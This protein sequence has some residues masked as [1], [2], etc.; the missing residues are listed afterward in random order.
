MLIPHQ[1][2]SSDALQGL[3]EDFIHRE[4]TD[5]G[6]VEASLED[7]VS[8]VRAQLVSGDVVILFDPVLESV[9]VVTQHQA[10]QWMLTAQQQNEVNDYE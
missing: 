8:Q 4:G 7:K 5:Y 2:L 9:N 6:A 10:K 3:I 1:Q